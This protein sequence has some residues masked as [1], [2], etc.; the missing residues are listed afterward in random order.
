MSDDTTPPQDPNSG[1]TPPP[2][3]GS[4]V[5]PAAPPPPPPPPAGGAMPPPPPPPYGAPAAGAPG[6]SYSPVEAI[7][8][9]WAK[10]TKSPATL[11]VPVLLTFVVV[12]VVYALMFFVILAPAFDTGIN[13]NSDGTVRSFDNGPGFV[14]TLIL[15]GILVLVVV[16]ALQ[17]LMAGLL[18]GGLDVADGKSPS[19]GELFQGWDKTQVLIAAVLIAV[20]TG[21]GFALCYLPGVIFSFLASYTMLFVIDK[22]MSAMDAIKASISFT[23]SHLGETILFFLL[24]A[25]V[26]AI[27]GVLCGIGLLAAYPVVLIAQAYTFR[28]LNNETVTPAA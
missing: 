21:V 26:T 6:G 12:A 14:M 25:V 16:F 23:T 13:Y 20:G 19:I 17:V 1:A 27:G 5:P 18:K 15:I 2:P 11:L 7:Q 4:E 24:S 8:Y 28:V 3:S 9:G 22:K 10:F